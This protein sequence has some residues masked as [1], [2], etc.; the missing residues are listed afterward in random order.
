MA[1]LKKGYK[2]AV[3]IILSI[4][5]TL[6]VLSL[7]TIN[8][9]EYFTDLNLQRNYIDNVQAVYSAESAIN[10]VLWEASQHDWLWDTDDQ[11]AD[12]PSTIALTYVGGE[13]GP[14]IQNGMYVWDNS[15]FKFSAKAE[16]YNG[17]IIVYV[18]AETNR[19]DKTTY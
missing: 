15:D 14:S 11:N 7:T 17:A 2:K 18:K 19:G 4:F 10:I 12:Y 9:S 1:S 6:L 3:A 13:T 8:F 16:D 5:I